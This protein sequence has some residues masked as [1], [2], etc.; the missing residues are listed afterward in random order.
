MA[1]ENANRDIILG[2]PNGVRIEL[3]ASEAKIVLYDDNNNVMIEIDGTAIFE[4]NPFSSINFPETAT[5]LAIAGMDAFQVGTGTLIGPSVQMAHHK[6]DTG[7]PGIDFKPKPVT[8]HTV[9]VGRIKADVDPVNNGASL[10][11]ESPTMDGREPA[12]LWLTADSDVAGPRLTI[13]ADEVW[14][15]GRRNRSLIQR[16]TGSATVSLPL[17]TTNQ[18]VAGT[19]ISITTTTPNVLYTARGYFDFNVTV[20]GVGNCIGSFNTSLFGLD[21]STALLTL[22]TTGRVNAQQEWQG[23]LPTAGTYNFELVAL[24]TVASGTAT[25]QATHSKL[26]MEFYE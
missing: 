24:K 16:S 26:V 23:L 20:A 13:S 18:T 25:A 9:E 21:G 10:Q 5:G 14:R 22:P 19:Q 17:S 3:L 7:Q 12:T 2:D 1:F 6:Y 11:I 4:G 15:N 8:G